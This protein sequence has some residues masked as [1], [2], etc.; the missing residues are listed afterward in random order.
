MNRKSAKIGMWIWKLGRHSVIIQMADIAGRERIAKENT[1]SWTCVHAH[2]TDYSSFQG[3]GISI[4][5]HEQWVNHALILSNCALSKEIICLCWKEK[6]PYNVVMAEANIL[7]L[8]G[9]SYNVLKLCSGM[10]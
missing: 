7:E 2:F 3:P 8:C 6:E 4:P 9:Y 1:C 5:F 10:I